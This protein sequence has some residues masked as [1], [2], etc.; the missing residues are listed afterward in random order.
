M[1]LQASARPAVRSKTNPYIN[2]IVRFIDSQTG[3]TLIL[4]YFDRP[5]R[6]SGTVA[7]KIPSTREKYAVDYDVSLDSA[8]WV[9]LTEKGVESRHFVATRAIRPYPLLIIGPFRCWLMARSWK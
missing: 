5:C 7:T 2:P 1:P 3:S 8:G 4:V 9:W 6:L